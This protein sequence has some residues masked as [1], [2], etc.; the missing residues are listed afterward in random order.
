MPCRLGA[1]C[2][3]EILSRLFAP[4]K[5]T[6]RPI[7]PGGSALAPD[8]RSAR[9]QIAWGPLPRAVGEM[10]VIKCILGGGDLRKMEDIH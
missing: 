10:L 6:V 7:H 2:R 9:C 4:T 5:G 1:P 8:L 3:D